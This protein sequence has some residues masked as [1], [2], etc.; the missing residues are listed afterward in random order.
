MEIEDLVE[1]ATIK[2]KNGAATM[3]RLAQNLMASTSDKKKNVTDTGMEED[4]DIENASTSAVS[5]ACGS[6]PTEATS[7]CAATA[8]SAARTVCPHGT[9]VSDGDAMHVEE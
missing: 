2:R 7:D 8:S 1:I 9:A 6:T 5:N 3:C 4:S